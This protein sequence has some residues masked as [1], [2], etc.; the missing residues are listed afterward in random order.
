M[1]REGYCMGTQMKKSISSEIIKK[2]LISVLVIFLTVVAVVVVM[3]SNISQTAK[4]TELT[5]ESKATSYQVERFFETYMATVEQFALN[6][7]IQRVFGEVKAGEILGEYATYKA[8]MNQM[9]NVV[10][11]DPENIM[12]VWMAD[13]D[14]SS[15]MTSD[16]YVSD[17]TF[18]M[19]SREWYN[20]ATKKRT[21]LTTP[22]EDEVTGNIV[23]TV[24]TPVYNNEKTQVNGLVGI[25][26]MLTQVNEMLCDHTIGKAGF[27]TLL[28]GDG[29]FVYH[30][31]KDVQ[32]K[33]VNNIDISS[34]VASALK[35]GTEQFM[36]YKAFGDTKYGYLMRIGDN[37]LYI[38]SN[39]PS[40]EFTADQTRA[41]I[42]LLIVQ[43]I[44]IAI[45]ILL[46][47]RVAREIT[48]PIISLNEVAQ[49]LATGNLDVN[50]TVNKQNEIG[51][52]SSSIAQT[53]ARL[54]T[55]I[56]Y[57][58]EISKVLNQ[59]ADGK[60]KIQLHHDYTGEFAKV[61]DALLHISA[62]MRD[63]M[64]NIIESAK[65][66]SSGADDLA[67]VSQ[68]IAEGANTQAASVEELMAT[69]NTVAYQVSENSQD[70]QKSSA[71]TKNVERMMLDSQNSMNQM[72]TAMTRIS[73]T[74]QQVVGIIKAI[75]DIASQTNLLALNASIEAARAGDAGR[76]FAVVATEI[77]SLADE[78]SKAAH[79]TKNLISLS[80]EEINRGVDLA[81]HVVTSLQEVMQATGHVNELIVRT[82]DNCSIQAQSM[83]QI[84]YA[85]EDIAKG[86]EDNSAVSEES[87]AT[88]AELASQ[89]TMLTDLVQ[90][91]ELN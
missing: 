63:V 33:N 55:Y 5:L 11:S 67:N 47:R 28:S 21:I 8:L 64:E 46:V 40:K 49:Q 42:S 78:S 19:K 85:I 9:K 84:K 71:E 45:I 24:S 90:K 25:D 10:S 30:P 26:I 61:K 65:K 86:V 72:M 54:K 14:S 34:E 31:N 35:S 15:V 3:V 87:S 43:V 69:A 53:V 89:A 76:G 44:G 1:E 50:I 81:N 77:G 62:S 57:I 68:S 16:G 52:L 79:D 60:L 48:Q 88:S 22:Y 80:I 38:L 59:I 27:V 51:E 39:M 70:A 20:A 32:L 74:S 18:E 13:I 2:V 7:S 29:T 82:A 37:D 91:F 23:I 6:T 66:V 56:D 83:E 36:K 58:D 12:A 73:E 75:E 41:I 4:E 17:G